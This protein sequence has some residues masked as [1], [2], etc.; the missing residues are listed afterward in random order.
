LS[1]EENVPAEQP[2]TEA[3]ARLPLSDGYPRRA[4]HT[5]AAE[6]KGA[7]AA[8]GQHPTKAA[9]MTASYRYPKTARVRRRAEFVSLQRDGSRRHTAHLIVIRRPAHERTRL[10]VTVS[11][12]IGNAV[13]RNRVKRLLREAFRHRQIEIQPPLDVVVIAKP[14]AEKLTYAQAATEFARGLGLET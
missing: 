11:K 6:E 7:K 8:D 5:Q 12:R 4:E 2:S 13:V 3:D 9:G 10:G 1:D 14:G